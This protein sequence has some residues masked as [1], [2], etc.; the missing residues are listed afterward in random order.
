MRLKP[1]FLVKRDLE[2]YEI[3]SYIKQRFFYEKAPHLTKAQVD[4]VFENLKC[5]LYLSYL[6]PT[7]LSSYIVDE[8]WHTFILFSRD[9]RNFCYKVFW[10]F[11]HHSPSISGGYANDIDLIQKSY[12]H[13]LK[14]RKNCKLYTLD[15]ELNIKGSQTK[16][17]ISLNETDDKIEVLLNGKVIGSF[18]A[19]K[20]LKN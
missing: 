16:G 18:K 13:L 15:K 4:L 1:L 20:G 17:I 12:Y 19:P 9:Y 6:K 2:K 7:Y 3:P 14:N 8:A 10:K 11:I 5:Y